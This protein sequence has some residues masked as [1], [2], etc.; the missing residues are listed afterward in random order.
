MSGAL[1]AYAA[2]LGQA[3]ED[4][5]AARANHVAAFPE[6]ATRCLEEVD[7]P[8]GLSPASILRTVA[9]TPHLVRQEDPRGVFGNPPLTLWRSRDFFVSALFWLDGTTSVHQHAFSGAFRVL[10]G[11]SIHAPYRFSRTE[12]ITHRLVLG[13]LQLDGPELL[14]VGDVRTIEPGGAFIHGLF[15]LERPSVTLVVRTYGQPMY[16]PQYNYLRPGVGYDSFY[17]DVQLERRFDS[18]IALA[19]LDPDAGASAACEFIGSEDLWVGYL[20]ARRWF[21]RADRGGRLQ[22]LLEAL[23][24]RHGDVAGPLLSAFDHERRLLSITTRRKLLTD[25]EHRLFMALLLNLPD[26]ASVDRVL[27]QRFPSEDPGA[28]L[29]RWITELASPSHRGVSGLVMNE[30]DIA[31]VAGELRAGR[32]DALGAI[33]LAGA[34]AEL[35]NDLFSS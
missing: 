1:G 9:M 25:P 13:D 5:W 8:E 33:K 14:R 26:R 27:A 30:A 19:S 24:K 35:L 29:A 16:E 31:A 3:I 32:A 22:Q 2:G 6:V 34:P 15:H 20:M 18:V 17:R 4:A 12:E 11:G 23:S 21:T 10:V 7:V 28:L